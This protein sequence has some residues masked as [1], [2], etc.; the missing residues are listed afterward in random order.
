M[1]RIISIAL[2][3][4][5]ILSLFATIPVSA[6]A[7]INIGEYVQMG[8]YYGK[9]ILWR[10]VDIDENGPLMLSDRIICLKAFD[11]A[12]DNT[13]GSHG[14]GY[15][16]NGTQGYYRQN[17]GSNYWA[18]S[19]IRDWLNST[20]SAGNVVWSCGNPPDNEHVYEGYNDYADEAGFLS[21][22][23][24]SERKA[25]K[26]VTQKSLLDGYEHSDSS[27]IINEN[28]HRY[29]G[30][31]KYDVLQNYDMAYSEQITDKIFLLDIKQINEVY[32][33]RDILGD[34]YYAGIPTEEALA[35]SE[36]KD[37]RL[38]SNSQWASLLRSPSA[39]SNSFWIRGFSSANSSFEGPSFRGDNGVR[40]AFYLDTGKTTFISGSG[41]EGNP[42]IIDNSGMKN[43]DE[44]ENLEF[45]I[46]N[47]YC[48]E[49]KRSIIWG[50]ISING[51]DHE[52]AADQISMPETINFSINAH[53]VYGRNQNN[54]Q[55][56]LYDSENKY[57]GG[58]FIQ[59]PYDS[60]SCNIPNGVIPNAIRFD[61]NSIGKYGGIYR[62]TEDD[63]KKYYY[64]ETITVSATIYT[65][66]S[67]KDFEL[68]DLPEL[69]FLKDKTS[70]SVSDNSQTIDDITSKIT[71]KSSD[72]SIAEVC[73]VT[74]LNNPDEK[75]AIINIEII[76]HKI[77]KVKITGTTADGKKAEAVVIVTSR[78]DIIL[79]IGQK[80]AMVYGE[81]KINDVAPIIRNDRTMLPARF[82]AESLGATVEW[83]GE[84]QKVVIK[85]DG[86]VINLHIDSDKAY[87]NGKQVTLD[88]PA[89][90]ESDR[91]FTPI[92]FI[93]ENLGAKVDWSEETQTVTITK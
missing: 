88:S 80:N 5:I 60:W 24:E 22:F 75:S 13:S 87:V 39:N 34:E 19:N 64:G 79:A 21:N 16:E 65:G 33:N 61:G 76:G 52:K 91:T 32:N 36:Y 20:A 84:E 30:F 44:Q 1:K 6:T 59:Y 85:K 66:Y 92:R 53:D 41:A 49:N 50:N 73:N 7:S 51:S 26:T 58:T 48:I 9:P 38:N 74:Y 54:Y 77:G 57:I 37:S 82:V 4:C 45:S 18:D 12:G 15:Y 56:S 63:L 86:I 69:S 28:Y 71:W 68:F 89:F 8:T 11:A 81:N 14:R 46:D 17:C 35:N 40:P 43:T 27:N 70:D 10:C 25:I 47:G 55:I 72:T 31:I 78:G 90:I 93:A 67:G 42:Y 2:A 29:S 23:T 62:L 3:I 83:V